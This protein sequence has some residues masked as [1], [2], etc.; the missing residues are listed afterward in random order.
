MY[1]PYFVYPFISWWTS[2]MLPPLGYCEKCCCEHGGTNICLGPYFQ[3]F[4]VYTPKWNAG[5]YGN[6][7]SHFWRDHHPILHPHQRRT[8]VPISLHPH[9]HL[10]FSV[11]WIRA[12][13]MGV[14]RYLIVILMCISVMISE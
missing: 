3:F 5:T 2:G 11:F 10:L 8:R 9:Q 14:K 12:I 4:W 1:I 13:L 7:M 6:F